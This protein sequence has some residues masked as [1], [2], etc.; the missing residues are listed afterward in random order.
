MNQT[1]LAEAISQSGCEPIEN[2]FSILAG[3]CPTI[4]FTQTGEKVCN[5][6]PCQSCF[7]CRGGSQ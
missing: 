2:H 3:P 7:D 5:C 6:E 1:N 4:Q